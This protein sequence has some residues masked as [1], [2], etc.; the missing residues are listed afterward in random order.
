M[1]QALRTEG[2][3][4]SSSTTAPPAA[5]RTPAP[6]RQRPADLVRERRDLRGCDRSARRGQPRRADLVVTASR[7]AGT[8]YVAKIRG[9]ETNYRSTDVNRLVTL[10]STHRGSEVVGLFAAYDG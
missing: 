6:H 5:T 4:R 3:R 9:D 10:C 1:E 7:R 8:L 2:F